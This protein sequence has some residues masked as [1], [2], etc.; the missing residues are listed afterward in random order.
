MGKSFGTPEQFRAAIDNR[1]DELEM[2]DISSST[3][4]LRAHEAVEGSEN[5][6][7]RDAKNKE[8]EDTECDFGCV[9]C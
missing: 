3:D 6:S 1:I 5:L 9:T 7:V 2:G 4:D 8:Q